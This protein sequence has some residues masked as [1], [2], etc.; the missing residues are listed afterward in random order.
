[1]ILSPST[2]TMV[3]QEVSNIMADTA[4]FT[5]GFVTAELKQAVPFG[6]VS[7]GADQT[8]ALSTEAAHETTLSVARRSRLEH[9]LQLS[10]TPRPSHDEKA[11]EGIRFRLPRHRR[12]FLL[13]VFI[14]REW[15]ARAR[16]GRILYL[17][18]STCRY[19]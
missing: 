15:H 16:G 8:Y 10:H 6:L 11:V 1:M 13:V 14:R 12:P 9:R 3:S 2:R 5:M 19:T 18:V 4:G 17:L 7:L